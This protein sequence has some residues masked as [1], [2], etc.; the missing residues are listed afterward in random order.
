MKPI[1]FILICVIAAG[2]K[3]LAR[4]NSLDPKNPNAEAGQIAVIENF[5]LHYTNID[6]IPPVVRNS[7]D[8]LYELKGDY[9]SSALIL[10]Y[11]M[12][13]AAYPAYRDT[14]SS[15]DIDFRYTN[16]YKGSTARGFPH[17]FFNGKQTW[18]QGASSQATAK[19]RYKLILDSLTLKKVKLF[20]EGSVQ[21]K[22]DSLAVSGQIARYGD[23]EISNLLVEML[24]LEDRGDFLHFVV[25]DQLQSQT[26]T[27]IEPETI[28]DLEKRTYEIPPG[29]N[30]N[31][32]S[33]VII[34]KDNVSERILQAVLAE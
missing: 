23:T 17:V 8:A 1:F 11:H 14:F 33:V 27:S 32:L 15:P 7:Q 25:R 30:K 21:I 18:I 2:C 9:G 22:G 3:D 28:Y 4:D 12:T 29:Y 34:I 31:N 26:V 6:S 5:I 20:C 19:D 13:P 16:K 24:V 10:E